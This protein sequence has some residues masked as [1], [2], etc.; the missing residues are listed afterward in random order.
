MNELKTHL[1]LLQRQGLVD[2]WHDRNISAEAE[3]IRLKYKCG[4]YDLQQYKLGKDLQIKKEDK[5]EESKCGSIDESERAFS[6]SERLI[7]EKL[8]SEGKHVKASAEGKGLEMLWLTESKPNLKRLILVLTA[9][10]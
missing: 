8:Q 3:C 7:A 4:R 6:L 9:Q 5:V 10:L 1:Q 2:I